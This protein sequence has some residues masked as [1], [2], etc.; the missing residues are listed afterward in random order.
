MPAIARKHTRN[1]RDRYTEALTL[2]CQK[3]T[4]FQEAEARRISFMKENVLQPYEGEAWL[5]KAFEEDI[6][7]TRTLPEAIRQYREPQFDWGC[8]RD[9]LWFLF[10]CITTPMQARAKTNPAIF[11][12][13]SLRIWE[14]IGPKSLGYDSPVLIDGTEATTSI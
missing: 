14:L 5:L 7:S 2:A 13:Q 4:A 6:L 12:A 8:P 11:A 1:G 10:N 3:L 9:S